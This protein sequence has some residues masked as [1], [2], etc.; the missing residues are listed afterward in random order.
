VRVE[1]LWATC[2]KTSEKK[3]QRINPFFLHTWDT[4]F[5]HACRKGSDL[6]SWGG[7][8]RSFVGVPPPKEEK[9]FL[10]KCFPKEKEGLRGKKG[11]T[12]W[13]VKR[14]KLGR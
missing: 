4:G 8:L 13:F 9:R 1:V 11:E 5:P 2:N 6:E 10:H 7:T 14:E 3:L 12:M